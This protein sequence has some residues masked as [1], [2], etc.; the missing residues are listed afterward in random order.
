MASLCA[1]HH[2]HG[3]HQ[4]WVRVRGRAPEGLTW[5]QGVRPGGTPLVVMGIH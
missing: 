5:E 2:L 3:V 4:G 1:A